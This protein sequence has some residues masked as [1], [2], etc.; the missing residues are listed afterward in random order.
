ML[1]TTVVQSRLV[2]AVRIRNVDDVAPELNG[3]VGIRVGRV[4]NQPV[5]VVLIDYGGKPA[6]ALVKSDC[7]ERF[8]PPFT[9]PLWPV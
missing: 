4:R 1:K 7:L 6:T 9:W 8:G 2:W 5:E 3:C